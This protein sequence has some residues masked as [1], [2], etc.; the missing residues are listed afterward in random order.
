MTST[1]HDLCNSNDLHT[2]RRRKKKEER[3]NGC[4]MH[5][6]HK[7]RKWRRITRTPHMAFGHHYAQ[8]ISVCWNFIPDTHQYKFI[9]KEDQKTG[10][11]ENKERERESRYSQDIWRCDASQEKKKK[12]SRYICIYTEWK[13]SYQCCLTTFWCFEQ[14]EQKWHKDGNEQRERETLNTY[15][16]VQWKEKW[17]Q[18]IT[19]IYCR[20]AHDRMNERHVE[21]MIFNSRLNGSNL[22]LTH[23]L[24]SSVQPSP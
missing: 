11:G 15:I 10:I 13:I 6:E 24:F 7:K 4:N 14:E 20:S 17:N 8:N 12:K 19:N 22:A 16:Y 5:E 21:E 9:T 1:I 18:T 3:E 23:L 2:R